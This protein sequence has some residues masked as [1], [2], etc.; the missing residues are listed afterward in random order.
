MI[1]LIDTLIQVVNPGKIPAGKTELPFQLSI[2]SE[3]NNNNENNVRLFETY[4]GVKINID[5][6]IG[7]EIKRS[8]ILASNV[9]TKPQ[10]FFVENKTQKSEK[11]EEKEELTKYEFVM[12]PETLRKKKKKK[13]K[14][15][16]DNSTKEISDFCI[17][18]HLD[19]T[20]CRLSD[21]LV[22]IVV[23]ERS[24]RP[25]KSLELQLLRVESVCADETNG[26]PTLRE[27]SEVQNIQVKILTKI[28]YLPNYQ[29]SKYS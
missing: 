26:P 8:G 29:H 24:D 4:H 12:T 16:E 9:V 28:N 10:E 23:V 19:L 27:K 18:G 2:E 20:R 22:G 21:P 5:Y 6:F 13:T 15:N 14:T 3:S 25:I 17:R 7:A 11:T 1:P